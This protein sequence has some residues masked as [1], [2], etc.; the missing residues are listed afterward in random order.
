MNKFIDKLKEIMRDQK[1]DLYL[2][3]TQDEFLGE[4]V[5][6]HGKRLE[7]LTNFTGSNGMAIFNTKG[8][9]YF[10]TDG[11]Y[12][13]QASKQLD[14]GFKIVDM[15]EEPLSQKL[16]SLTAEGLTLGIDP[17]LHNISQIEVISK[18]V[19]QDR[20][21][22]I[23][24]NIVDDIW[25][26]KPKAFYSDIGMHPLKF[27]GESH[28]NKKAKILEKLRE[29]GV[30]A[31]IVM[32]PHSVCWLLN[33][34]GRDLDYTPLLLARAI[35]H[36]SGDIDLFCN[37]SADEEVIK[38]FADNN[39][40]LNPSEKFE[41]KIENLKSHKVSISK[42]SPYWLKMKL[43]NALIEV[44]YCEYPKAIKNKVELEGAKIAHERDGKAVTKLIEWVQNSVSKGEDIT[45]YDVLKKSVEFRAE[46][47]NFA[48]PSFPTIAGF[49][50]NGAIIHYKPDESSKKISGNGLLLID[51][52]GQYLE[53]T[54][55]IT[56]TIS[57]GKPT[58][59]QIHDFT[60]VLK[61]YIAVASAKF[62]PGTTGEYLDK[63]ARQYLKEDGKD[64]AHGTGHGVGSFLSVHEGPHSIS[65]VSKVPFAPGMIVSI[66]PGYYKEGEY[67]I[68]IESLAFV[69][70]NGS[71]LEF[72]ILTQCEISEDLINFTL[73][74]EDEK[75]YLNSYK[76]TKK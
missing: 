41:S 5:S 40:S 7:Y 20:R 52:G 45:E 15:R 21:V 55:D 43:P 74:S 46:Q 35:L 10:Y 28:G 32:N 50:E 60:L 6:D 58:K 4:Y 26:N 19:P 13:L 49:R 44:D 34:R 59:E 56:R 27:A 9:D 72:E 8:Q 53:G 71:I 24:S 70:E 30:D 38:Y 62:K 37:N 68:R 29:G 2:L 36:K 22:F 18:V 61:G 12:M 63:L 16:K 25:K 76:T 42:S 14:P 17:K 23:E 31:V 48:C 67:G 64:Y 65:H 54:T 33:I 75:N 47:K 73:L 69:K 39:I 11:R 51:G 66:E 57:I 1:V 3:P